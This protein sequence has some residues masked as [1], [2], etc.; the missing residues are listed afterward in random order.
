MQWLFRMMEIKNIW[1]DGENCLLYPLGKI[2][3]GIAAIER[4]CTDKG[5]QEHL[6]EGGIKTAQSRDWESIRKEIVALY[7]D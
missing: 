5:L 4:I 7:E 3:K 2:E 6:Y 1:R